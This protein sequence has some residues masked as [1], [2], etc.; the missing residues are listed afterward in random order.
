MSAAGGGEDGVVELQ[1]QASGGKAGGRAR[2]H[3]SQ[4][5]RRPQH[6][7]LQVTFKYF[8]YL[9]YFFIGNI[10]IIRTESQMSRAYQAQEWEK[11]QEFLHQQVIKNRNIT[12]I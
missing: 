5:G 9:K 7:G 11:Q 1:L 3:G 6:D 2:E 10:F 12:N 8:F 4:L